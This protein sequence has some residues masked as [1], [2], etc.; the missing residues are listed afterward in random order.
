MAEITVNFDAYDEDSNSLIVSFT[1]GVY[2]TRQLAFQ[3]YNFH[4]DNLEVIKKNLAVCGR[5]MIEAM[6]REEEYKKSNNK[7]REF[8]QLV[9]TSVSYDDR[10][11]AEVVKMMNDNLEVE[12]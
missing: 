3:P 7:Q 10:E 6:K 4:D 11:I 9:G 12:L 5:D 2:T 8:K 1:D